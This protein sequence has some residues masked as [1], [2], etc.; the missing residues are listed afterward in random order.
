[1]WALKRWEAMSGRYRVHVK[2]ISGKGHSVDWVR[3]L[4]YTPGW[5]LGVTVKPGGKF[6]QGLAQGPE[7]LRV[8]PIWRPSLAPLPRPVIAFHN[9]VFR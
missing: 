5:I 4:P 8:H 6:T 7:C 9:V 2:V 1:M 3:D